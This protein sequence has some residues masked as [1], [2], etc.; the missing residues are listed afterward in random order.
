MK[1]VIK[2]IWNLV[3]L[4]PGFG[5]F[6]KSLLNISKNDDNMLDNRMNLW[7]FNIDVEKVIK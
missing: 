1:I 2:L 6:V 7:I 3:K 5:R 4:L